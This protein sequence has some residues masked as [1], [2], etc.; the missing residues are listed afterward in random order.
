MPLVVCIQVV[1]SEEDTGTHSDSTE[2]VVEDPVE[3]CEKNLISHILRVQGEIS[4]RL[5][6]IEEEV[7]SEF[8]ILEWQN[9]LWL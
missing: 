8:A 5:D 4:E 1:P 2:S 7:T 9:F 3:V 6:K